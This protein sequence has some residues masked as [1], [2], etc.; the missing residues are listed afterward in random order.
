L[1]ATGLK[2]VKGALIELEERASQVSFEDF[3][4]GGAKES[5]F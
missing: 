5:S 1:P 4:E 2:E 3:S